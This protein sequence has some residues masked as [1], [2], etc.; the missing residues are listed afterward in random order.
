MQPRNSFFVLLLLSLISHSLPAQN[1][2]YAFV[3]D[4]HIGSQNADEDLRRTVAD[5]NAQEDVDFVII[6]GDITEMGTNE[7]L[8]LAKEILSKLKKPYYIIPGNHDTGWSESG[9]V[10]VLQTFGYDKFVFD[11]KGYRIMGCASGP[12]V[13][14][15]DGH[16]PRDATLWLDSLLAKTPANM[17]IVFA[18]HYPIDNSL[19]NWYEITDRLKEKNIQ[20]VICG[21]GHANQ[22]LN[23]EGISGTMSRSNLRAKDSLGGYNIVLM[24]NDTAYFAVKKPGLQQEQVWRKIDLQ[25]FVQ[26]AGKSFERPSYSINTTYRG[27]KAVWT[28]QSNANVVNTPAYGDGKVVFGNS[29]GHIEAL[30]M[31]TGKKMWTYKTGGA[32]Y[33]S[34]QIQK[35]TVVVGSGD[36][37]VYALNLRSGKLKWKFKTGAAVLGSPILHGDTVFIG[38]SDHHFRAININNG[39]EIWSFAGVEGAV[40]DKPLLYERKVIFGSW[41]RNLHALD[42]RNGKEIWSWNNGSPNRMFSP[43]MVTPVAHNGVVYIV[44]PDRFL[45]AIDAGNGTTL[46]RTKQAGFRESLGI[47]SDGKWLYGKTMQ[48]SVIA[49]ATQKNEPAIA[50]K[51]HVGF[52]YEHAPSMLTEQSGKVF[53]GT[54][55]G[56]V[57][58]IDPAAQKTIWAHKIDNA[59]V[60]TVNVIDGKTVLASTMDGK[61]TLLN[62]Q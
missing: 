36:G 33:S 27:T 42:S 47:S 5:I 57:Y 52:G 23:F 20:Y 41:G 30:D 21:H 16:V 25:N 40:V 7:E 15:S 59:M 26:S 49:Y 19:D 44:A 37:H 12:Y 56:V 11:F 17:P 24:Q 38:G 58:A 48:D 28:Y 45:T 55:N 61:V 50:W 2:K 3:T 10:F 46:W 22:A 35:Q 13:R 4:T 62:E 32:I 18:N 39:K 34:A 8:L 6:T 54:R 9:G 53:F 31:Q 14:M 29:I 60:N 43:A 51:M 1:I